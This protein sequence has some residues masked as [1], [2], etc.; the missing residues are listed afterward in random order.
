M[1]NLSWEKN[2]RSQF[3]LEN[4]SRY[5]PYRYIRYE[6]YINSEL[7]LA[8]NIP[9]VICMMKYYCIYYMNGLMHK[10]CATNLKPTNQLKNWFNGLNTRVSSLILSTFKTKTLQ[11]LNILFNDLFLIFRCNIYNSRVNNNPNFQSLKC[12]I[13]GI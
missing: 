11:D 7:S 4:D 2:L 3:R 12:V 1:S 10:I 8:L 9:S 5:T 6:S 13:S